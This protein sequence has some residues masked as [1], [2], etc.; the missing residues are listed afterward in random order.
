MTEGL[1]QETRSAIEELKGF[2]NADF[3]DQ[4]NYTNLLGLATE[5]MTRLCYLEGRMAYLEEIAAFYRIQYAAA[6]KGDAQPV[7]A[8]APAAGQVARGEGR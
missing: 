7:V 6:M 1:S 8:E 2:T 3:E 5:L 4:D